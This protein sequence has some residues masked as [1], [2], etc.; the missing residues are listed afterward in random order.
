MNLADARVVLRPRTL[1]EILDLAALW[2]FAA[3]RWLYAR[4]F[5]LVLLPSLLACVAA[6]WLGGWSWVEVW[7][8]AVGLATV[9]QGV[10][11]VATSRALF[12]RAVPAGLVLRLFVRRLPAYLGALVVTR[13][14]LAAS[15]VTL[16]LLPSGWIRVAMVHE[17]SLLENGSP[18]TAT[19]RAWQLARHRGTELVLL[20]GGQLLALVAGIGALELLGH[21]LVEVVLQLGRPF[22]ELWEDGGSL[23]ALVG[24]H[25][26]IPYVAVARFL[27]YVDHRTR[28]DGWDI[29]LRFMALAAE[30][31]AGAPRRVA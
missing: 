23:Y 30:E 19:E 8:L 18:I 1:G 25:A 11:T 9:S 16:V 29:Q 21:G 27:A 2:C 10:F 13:L 5:A 15:A 22:G 4:L 26:A 12:Q 3:D 31:P 20:L 7:L 28:G 14:I 24:F 6:R 17:A